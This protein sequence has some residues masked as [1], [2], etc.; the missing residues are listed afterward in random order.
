MRAGSA[1][2]LAAP[3]DLGVIHIVAGA[4][5]YA[6]VMAELDVTQTVGTTAAGARE[7]SAV[8]RSGFGLLTSYGI[9]RGV[10]RAVRYLHDQHR[11]APTKRRFRRRVVNALSDGG[12]LRVHH[13]MRGIAIAFTS[14]AIA[15]PRSRDDLAFSLS[16]AFGTGAGLA[17]DKILVLLERPNSY[18]AHQK[19]AVAQCAA[20]A[21]AALA[22][23]FHRRARPPG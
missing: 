9:T 20:V 22:V 16:L 3:T 21:A 19:I 23:R 7:A 15:I 6:D 14:D 11:P 12:H 4:R 1:G 10:A 2:Q 17:F 8:E 13:Y 5:A 18:C